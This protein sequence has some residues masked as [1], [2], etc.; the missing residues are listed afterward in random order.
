MALQSKAKTTTMASIIATHEADLKFTLGTSGSGDA[1]YS[2][3][4]YKKSN[5]RFIEDVINYVFP[6]DVDNGSMKI[7][8]Q[9][10][11]KLQSFLSYINR[12]QKELEDPVFKERVDKILDIVYSTYD[13]LVT[14]D[15]ISLSW[16]VKLSDLYV[17]P[18]E[19]QD[20]R[21]G[22][23]IHS[24]P[25]GIIREGGINYYIVY[26]RRILVSEWI[27]F[28]MDD[29][30]DRQRALL[31]NFTKKKES[32]YSRADLYLLYAHVLSIKNSLKK[33][34]LYTPTM[35]R[36]LCDIHNN[37][38]H[39]VLPYRFNSSDWVSWVFQAT[40]VTSMMR[41]NDRIESPHLYSTTYL[42]HVIK[43]ARI[44]D[45][46]DLPIKIL[47]KRFLSIT[48][49]Y[50]GAIDEF[51]ESI[52]SQTTLREFTAA[53]QALF[54]NITKV[55]GLADGSTLTGIARGIR[56]TAAHYNFISVCYPNSKDPS[57][58][59]TDNANPQMATRLDTPG[60]SYVLG[61]GKHAEIYAAV[62]PKNRTSIPAAIKL[63]FTNKDVFKTYVW[64]PGKT[65]FDQ[66]AHELFITMFTAA[67][68]RNHISPHFLDVLQISSCQSYPALLL[69]RMDGTFLKLR[70]TYLAIADAMPYTVSYCNYITNGIAQVIMALM[71]F[72]TVYGMHNDLHAGNVFLKYCDDTEFAGVPLRNI[73]EFQYNI[74]L[75]NPDTRDQFEI[76]V[77]IPNIGILIKLGDYGHSQMTT[78]EVTLVSKRNV[79]NTLHYSPPYR[80]VR[81]MV[82]FNPSLRG[83]F[84]VNRNRTIYKANPTRDF[85]T[86]M[87]SLCV[88]PDTHFHP[89]V[90]EFQIQLGKEK[91]K[92]AMY[93]ADN[94]F[95]GTSTLKYMTSRASNVD[96]KFG[97]FSFLRNHDYATITENMG[98]EQHTSDVMTPLY[99]MLHCDHFTSYLSKTRADVLKTVRAM[100]SA[101]L[102][103]M[104]TD[105][106]FNTDAPAMSDSAWSPRSTPSPRNVSPQV[107]DFNT[108]VFHNAQGTP[109]NNNNTVFYNAQ[110]TK[111]VSQQTPGN[112]QGTN[113]ASQP[114]TRRNVQNVKQPD[115]NTQLL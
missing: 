76:V 8:K 45:P 114:K 95:L 4:V 13:T 18:E 22:L 102:N 104:I 90:H 112:V 100:T 38:Y 98:H 72:F 53:I 35:E 39:R 12:G 21:V 7:Y 82:L 28:S 109:T 66:H 31:H 52:Q 46:F 16:G 115:P 61:K 33:L 80:M 5:T 2:E 34:L 36:Y 56:N 30:L 19:D 1:G 27:N 87:N 25:L 11:K 81:N 24:P 67:M 91:N 79:Q 47:R 101:E 43:K 105:I 84:N 77:T 94:M 88:S 20:L 50:H 59:V 113:N 37:K 40:L 93:T 54:S 74:T 6:E 70:S 96:R 89:I 64:T 62:I 97:I 111:N 106:V 3:Y 103:S 107:Q 14:K 108:Q 9:K 26:D 49:P 83:V 17:T 78:H 73:K 10:P 15:H 48:V 71:A 29:I 41:T 57:L 86:F 99:F 58:N 68:Y 32:V 110:E 65:E 75:T 42:D 92:K 85:S 51:F 23:H 69:E 55:P 44:G 60:I 63:F